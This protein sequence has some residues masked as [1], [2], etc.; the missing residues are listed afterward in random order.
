MLT[1]TC[2]RADI[3]V[4]DFGA[5]GDGKTD[6]TNAIKRAIERASQLGKKLIF[7]QGVYLVSYIDIK[8]DIEGVNG[9]V[10][11]KKIN[12]KNNDVYVFCNVRHQV[13]ID[14]TNI[15]FDGNVEGSD[16]KPHLGAIPLFIYNSKNIKLT[17][18]TFVNSPSSC[19]RVESSNDISINQCFVSNA[20]GVFGDGI[21]IEDTEKVIVNNTKANNYTRIGFVVEKNSKD[22]KLVHCTASNGHDAS[23]LT[24]GTEFNAG[25]WAERA[26]NVHLSYCISNNNTHYGY[27]LT[28]GIDAHLLLGKTVDFSI[29]NSESYNNSIGF[30]VSS[31]GNPVKINIENCKAIKSTQGFLAFARSATDMFKFLNCTVGLLEPERESVNDAGFMWESQIVLKD[32]YPVF[33]YENCFINYLG[34]IPYAKLFDRNTNNADL[35]TYGG[36]NA[37]ILINKMGNNTSTGRPIIKAIKGD[38]KFQIVNTVPDLRYL[39]KK[40]NVIIK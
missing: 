14:I 11:I 33:I 8:V 38:P 16:V 37:S 22:V 18:C 19:L 29:M 27:V 32:Q 12:K 30:R 15:V 5:K 36:G 23:I 10:R 24:G 25:F 3:K 40:E 2:S 34:K 21:Y 35:S 39:I 13:S 4:K 26:A 9:K 20:N 17:N 6:D 28:S 31:S 7:Q 1:A